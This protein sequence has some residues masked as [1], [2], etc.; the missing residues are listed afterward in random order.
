[1][2]NRLIRKQY[3]DARNKLG[4]SRAQARQIRLE[5]GF[6]KAQMTDLLGNMYKNRFGDYETTP[7]LDSSKLLKVNYDYSD[8]AENEITDSLLQ[9]PSIA[10]EIN[11]KSNQTFTSPISK[12]SMDSLSFGKAFALARKS[13]AK[14]FNWR[15]KSYG[16][17]LAKS[18]SQDSSKNQAKSQQSQQQTQQATQQNVQQTAQ[19]GSAQGVADIPVE[20]TA[21]TSPAINLAGLTAFP[22]V[23]GNT[24]YIE[25]D[26]DYKGND[27]FAESM[28]LWS[29]H[30]SI[31]PI[32]DSNGYEVSNLQSVLGPNYNPEL[33][34][35]SYTHPGAYFP[36][37]KNEVRVNG[38]DWGVGIAPGAGTLAQRIS[39]ANNS[40]ERRTAIVKVPSVK[41]IELPPL[42]YTDDEINSVLNQSRPGYFARD[43][44]IYTNIGLSA[45]PVPHW[46]QATLMDEVRNNTQKK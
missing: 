4:M 44:V 8:P 36:N 27:D 9:T 18:I 31:Y 16:T 22:G 32:Y 15:G 21:Q 3:N 10:P 24:Y 46:L 30:S 11:V 5:N 19:Q 38:K 25:T 41:K 42:Q 33:H 43:G 1:M 29:G 14:T 28:G 39:Q 37:G 12:P 17:E 40:K 20:N 26:R 35:Y 2:A 13:G 23:D 7:G 34:E 45:H 6:N